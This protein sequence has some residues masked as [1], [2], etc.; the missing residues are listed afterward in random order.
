MI[1]VQSK[2]NKTPRNINLA[3]IVY[4]VFNVVNTREIFTFNF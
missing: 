2:N 1:L 4:Q 3:G